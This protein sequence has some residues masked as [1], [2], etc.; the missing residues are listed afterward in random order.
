MLE[1]PAYSATLTV[2]QQ[3]ADGEIYMK[4]TFDPL[5]S[6]TPDNAPVPDCYVFL[7]ELLQQHF[8]SL[9][10]VDEDGNV[11]SAALDTSTLN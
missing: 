7:Q 3:S 5:L 11:T 2:M 6:D 10:L 1:N 4:V 9:G 8:E